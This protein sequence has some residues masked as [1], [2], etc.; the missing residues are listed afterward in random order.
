MNIVILFDGICNL[1]NQSVQFIL[2]RD[3]TEKIQFA[4]LQG[5]FGSKMVAKQRHPNQLNSLILLEGT[6][7][8]EKSTAVLRICRYLNWPW[9]FFMIFL[10]VP[11]PI[12]DAVYT[13]IANHR[14]K[15]FGHQ[16]QCLLP[17]PKYKH[18]FID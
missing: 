8:Y 3:V 7:Q 10:I 16:E 14:Y 11:R 6:R 2:K 15:W 1:C 4:S 18:R 5:Q 13:Y 17:S 9:K 12:R